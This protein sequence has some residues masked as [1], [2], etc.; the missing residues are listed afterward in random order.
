[1]GLLSRLRRKNPPAKARKRSM[2]S[3]HVG[4]LTYGWGTTSVTSTEELRRDLEKIRARSREQVNNNPHLRRWVQLLKS[5]VI[6][7]QGITMQARTVSPSGKPDEA[8][9]LAL[10]MGWKEWGR[11]VDMGGRL[12]W[13]DAQNLFI[14][15]ASTDGEVFVQK[16]LTDDGFGFKLDF[17]DPQLISTQLNEVLT[18]GR[19]IVMGIE[20]DRFNRPLAYYVPDTSEIQGDDYYWYMNRNYKR[21]PADSIIHAFMPERVDQLRGVP[22]ASNAL[23]RM[24]MLDGYTEAEVTKAEGEA[25]KMMFMKQTDQAATNPNHD[26]SDE[27]GPIQELEPGLVE[28]LPFGWEPEPYDPT[29]PNANFAGFNTAILDQI[30]VSLGVSPFSLTGNLKGVNYTS[31]RTGLLEDRKAWEALQEWA[32][33]KFCRPVFESWLAPALSSG[34]M[35]LPGRDIPLNP[36]WEPKYRNVTWQGPRWQ[37]VDPQKEI[38]AH[39]T[40]IEL[41]VRSRTEIIKSLGREPSEVWAELDAEDEMMAGLT[42]PAEHPEGVE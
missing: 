39:K 2:A 13:R 6:G 31:S 1:M 29:S 35:L 10:E 23:L 9:N 37:W 17:I 16:H 21:V 42:A 3:A 19:R 18:G 32:A 20:L 15:T 40:A 36:A 8:A 26:D 22:W 14:S 7:P 11:D 30:S 34:Q 33:D 25:N 12:N 27:E 38:N 28:F 4:N 5:N 24:K 41:R